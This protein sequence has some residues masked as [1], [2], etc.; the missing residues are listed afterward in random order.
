MALCTTFHRLINNM[1]QTSN[2]QMNAS[3]HL[4]ISGHN[5]HKLFRR[6]NNSKAIG[7]MA[8][9][10]ACSGQ[11][12]CMFKD[13]FN[14]SCTLSMLCLYRNTIRQHVLRRQPVALISIINK[15][16]EKHALICTMFPITLDPLQFAH[17][18]NRSTE[19]VIYT[20]LHTAFFHMEKRNTYSTVQKF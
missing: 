13:I 14:L 16:F 9:L 7:Q 5:I 2:D 19:D 18:Y 10:W 4:S 12:A 15:C 1:L 3:L 6:V 11:L 20:A 17:H 8:S